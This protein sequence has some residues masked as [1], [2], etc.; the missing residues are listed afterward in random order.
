MFSLFKGERTTGSRPASHD[1]RATR[2][3]DLVYIVIAG[4]Y[5]ASL[6][7]SGQ[8]V[9]F[10]DS[11]S[12]LQRLYGTREK[13]ASVILA[14]VKRFVADMSFPRPFCTDNRTEY[15]NGLFLDYCK[16]SK[17]DAS[18]RR[19]TPRSKIA[20]SRAQHRELLRLGSALLEIPQLYPDVRL[21]EVRGCTDA[22]ART[23]G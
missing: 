19:R 13:S 17:F 22:G 23:Y 3:L 9:M 6:G 15:T 21:E 1:R 10:V 14:V 12:Q 5:P 8:V 20:L 18:S 7:G 4:P 11:A 16:T 2:P